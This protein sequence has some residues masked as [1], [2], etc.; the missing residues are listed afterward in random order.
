MRIALFW[1]IVRRVVII[2]DTSPTKSNPKAAGK[3][4]EIPQLAA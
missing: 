3:G 2:P 4:R 1:V